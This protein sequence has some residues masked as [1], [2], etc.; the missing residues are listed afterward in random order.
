MSIIRSF[1]NSPEPSPVSRQQKLSLRDPG[2]KGPMWISKQTLP[3]PEEGTTDILEHLEAAIR[4]LAS[5]ESQLAYTLPSI[6]PVGIEWTGSRTGA[7]K[8]APRPDLDE[9]GQYERLMGSVTSDVTVLYFHGGALYLMDPATHR[10]SCARLAKHTGGRCASVRYRLA[11]QNPFP[12]ALVDV[13]VAYLSLL[14]PPPG[15]VHTPVPAENI[16]FAG[17]SAGGTLCLTLLQ[18]ILQMHRTNGG[19]TPT[20]KFHDREVPVPVPAGLALLSPWVDLLRSLP[21]WTGNLRWD[22]LPAPSGD[23]ASVFKPDD[24]WPTTPARGDLYCETSM[25]DHRLANPLSAKDWKGSP[26]VFICI[27]EECLA[28]DGKVIARRLVE[29][30]S[31]VEFQEFE[32]MPHVFPAV[33]G[34]MSGARLA[35]ERWGYAIKRMV[36]RGSIATKAVWVAAKTLK[37]KDLTVSGLAPELTEEAIT[38]YVSDAKAQRERGQGRD[39][40]YLARL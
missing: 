4:A 19:K 39:E 22:Y 28:D 35:M 40:R 8:Q 11:P 37:E 23:I 34:G 20:V 12:A 1:M 30:G 9:E 16:V 18:L 3:V 21:S 24:I 25:L 5:D 14:S 7:N 36:E 2:I 15:A 27:G 31:A 13:F 33:F 32:A 17:D 6:Q 38:K 29:A 26:S 10:T